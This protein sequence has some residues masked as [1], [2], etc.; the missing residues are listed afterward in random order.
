MSDAEK[1]GSQTPPEPWP[2]PDK[3]NSEWVTRSDD[4]G[5]VNGAKGD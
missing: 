4:P 1:Q 5:K 2:Q 3:D